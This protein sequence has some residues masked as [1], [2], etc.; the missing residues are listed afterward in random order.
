MAGGGSR[1]GA[2]RA[3]LGDVAGNRARRDRGRR[4]PPPTGGAQLVVLPELATSGY[5]FADAE[6]ARARG[7]ADPGPTTDAWGGGRGPA[8]SWSG[9]SASSTTTAPLRNTAVVRRPRGA[10]GALPQAAPVGRETSCSRPAT[11][12]RRSS[13]RPPGASASASATTSGSPE[14]ARGLARSRAPRSWSSRSN[15]ST[16]PQDGLPHLDVVTAVATAHVNRVHLV[17][18]DRCGTERGQRVVGASL[19]VDAEGTLWRAAPD[20][21]RPATVARHG[22]RAAAATSAGA[23]ENKRAVRPAA[24]PYGSAV[25]P[26]R[27]FGAA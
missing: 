8:W 16:S 7:G 25:S 14:H 11:R 17:V 24:G 13:T 18:A 5:C 19:V 6:E 3:V 9:A 27:S 2:P 12:H 26:R 21:D 10:A 20:D 22:R 4:A 23:R 1:G 15:L